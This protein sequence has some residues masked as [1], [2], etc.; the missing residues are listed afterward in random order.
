MVSP[1]KASTDSNLTGTGSA[2]ACFL[3][4]R[5]APS[6]LED[7]LQPSN[8]ALV[9]LHLDSESISALGLKPVNGNEF[10]LPF[11]FIEVKN[12]SSRA[13]F[14]GQNPS[15]RPSGQGPKYPNTGMPNKFPGRGNTPGRG[16]GQNV[17]GR[18]Q[19][20]GRG[21]YVPQTHGAGPS[22]PSG[23]AGNGAH[24]G[25]WAC[26]ACKALVFSFRPDC[27]KCHT[28]RPDTDHHLIPRQPP[29][30]VNMPEGDVREGDWTCVGCK[31]H[32]FSS[33]LA[34]FTCRMPRPPGFIS[35]SPSSVSDI[36]GI[37]D[38]VSTLK[39]VD[40][41]SSVMPGD[42]NC[43]QCKENVFAKRFRCYKCGT[44]RAR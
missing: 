28:L 13:P 35:P 26:P 38:D 40:R 36:N 33:K 11:G 41:P 30:T 42:W 7:Q 43:P 32:N 25:D 14:Q 6:N 5:K 44:L 12:H 24:V 37:V 4:S 27:F 34:C 21:N 19:S 2:L 29:R 9:A 20:A 8:R 22:D 39:I 23:G 3:L 17:P 31:G 15:M 18:G 16:Q 1:V 10:Y